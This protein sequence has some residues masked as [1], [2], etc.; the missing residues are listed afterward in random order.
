MPETLTPGDGQDL[1]ARIKKARQKRDP[2]LMLE[3]FADGAEFRTDP[4]GE[5]LS[6]LTEIREHW[7]AVAAEQA[8]VDFDAERVWVSGR[9]VLTSWHGAYTRRVDGTRVRERG[10]STIEIN[11]AGRISRMRDWPT[12]HEIGEDSRFRPDPEPAA[13]EG[14]DG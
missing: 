13:G 5:P 6:G 14:Q 8:H 1:L 11:D 2:D 3:L 4:F 7:N 12:R 10:F 9:T